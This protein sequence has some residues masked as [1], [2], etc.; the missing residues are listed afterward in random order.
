MRDIIRIVLWPAVTGSKVQFPGFRMELQITT[1]MADGDHRE[2]LRL[3][4]EH[5]SGPISRFCASMVGSP[6]EAEELMQETFLDAWNAM[7][8]YRAESNVRAW[9][10]GIARRVCIRHL[11]RRDRRAGLLQRW[12]SPQQASVPP[13]DPSDRLDAEKLLRHGLQ[14][15][16]PELGTEPHVFYIALDK[17]LTGRIEES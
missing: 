8:T 2:A 12:L 5:Y 13:A 9:L 15:L 11:R 6:A 14:A 3:M 4:A 7:P 10:Y 16:K 1:F 17:E